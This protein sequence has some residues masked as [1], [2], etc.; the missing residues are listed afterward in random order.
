MMLTVIVLSLFSENQ[1]DPI[2]QFKSMDL[3]TAVT[4]YKLM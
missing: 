4:A 1:A 2:A 3:I